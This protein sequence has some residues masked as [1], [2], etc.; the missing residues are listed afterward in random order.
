MQCLTQQP[1]MPA[2]RAG[3]VRRTTPAAMLCCWHRRRLGCAVRAASYH[4]SL[5]SEEEGPLAAQKVQRRE[6]RLDCLQS[7]WGKAGQLARKLSDHRR[8]HFASWHEFWSYYRILAAV[9]DERALRR[10]SIELNQGQIDKEPSRL[11]CCSF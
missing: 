11:A 9:V 3:R 7:S 1:C 8:G 2:L 10:I 5:V 6:A 4:A